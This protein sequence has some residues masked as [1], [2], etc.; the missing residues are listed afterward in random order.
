[1]AI[2]ISKRPKNTIGRLFRKADYSCWKPCHMCMRS[3]N[4]SIAAGPA[5]TMHDFGDFGGLT[6]LCYQ[7][8]ARFVPG[9]GFD[10]LSRATPGFNPI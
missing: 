6:F 5:H 1:M 3:S 2:F 8:L 7:L 4:V 10:F 9:G